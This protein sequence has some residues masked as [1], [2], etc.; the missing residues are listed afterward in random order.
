M[1]GFSDLYISKGLSNIS[2]F[3]WVLSLS[4]I[5]KICALVFHIS[6]SWV[7]YQAV[8]TAA[9]GVGIEQDSEISYSAPGK[10]R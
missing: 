1:T 7:T 2:C 10:G 5:R 8:E 6:S 4:D 3:S 9:F